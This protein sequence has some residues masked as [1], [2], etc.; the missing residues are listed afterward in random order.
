MLRAG[1]ELRVH[2]SRSRRRTRRLLARTT[3]AVVVR[4]RHEVVRA[5][6]R[7]RLKLVRSHLLIVARVLLSRKSRLWQARFLH[8]RRVLLVV[9]L[10]RLE[11]GVVLVGAVVAVQRLRARLLLLIQIRLG[12]WVL[13][14]H[15]VAVIVLIGSALSTALA[16][17]VVRL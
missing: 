7:R 6:L 10:P 12:R 1:P 13:Q 15:L 4:V 17:V 8:G 9:Q 5:D 3:L 11:V 2:V 16:V 14:R